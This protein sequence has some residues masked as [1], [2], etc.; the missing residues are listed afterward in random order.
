MPESACT[1]E[2]P[3]VDFD[4]VVCP[5]PCGTMHQRCTAC[6]GTAEPCAWEFDIPARP[7]TDED[8][9]A[10]PVLDLG[11]LLNAEEER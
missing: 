1:H 5:D 6:G 4:R 11:A 8:I 10:L 2:G 3:D 9:A 7:V